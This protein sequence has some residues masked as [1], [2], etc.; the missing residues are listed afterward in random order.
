MIQVNRNLCTLLLGFNH[1]YPLAASTVIAGMRG[2]GALRE[3]SLEGNPLG[4]GGATD[5]FTKLL[6]VLQTMPQL[7]RLNVANTGCAAAIAAAT[8]DQIAH[9][10]RVQHLDLGFNELGRSAQALSQLAA[11]VR[12]C[13]TVQVKTLILDG[14]HFD[15]SV[16]PATSGHVIDI[17]TAISRR[18][19]TLSV[20]SNS[21]IGT[22]TCRDLFK[23][24]VDAPALRTV[25]V[26][27]IRSDVADSAVRLIEGA[28]YLSAL[29]LG[30]I[31]A[32]ESGRRRLRCR[33]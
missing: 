15:A 2:N 30:D 7:E 17:V 26:R 27:G 20:A 14:N 28:G 9:L 23:L 5:A 4:F 8:V 16:L 10:F 13:Q 21:K 29:D 12:A 31:V 22:Q 6:D 33:E 25:S 32:S 11:G 1:M 3:L 24:L 19:E 18:L